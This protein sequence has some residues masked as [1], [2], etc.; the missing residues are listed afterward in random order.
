MKR[1]SFISLGCFRNRY[2][3]E[4]LAASLLSSKKGLIDPDK[5]SLKN[6]CD[7]LV[8]NTCG[9][10]DPAKL[11]SLEVI[12][13]A[14]NLK[15]AKK[16]KEVYVFGC[17]VQR[18]RPQL[19]KNFPEVDKWWGRQDFPKIYQKRLLS[20]QPVD[21]VKICEGCINRCSYCAIPLIKGP[22]RSRPAQEILK[23]VKELEAAGV[24]ELNIIGQDT[25]SWAKDLEEEIDLTGL[26]QLILDKT[27]IE[28][29]RLIYAHPQH[30]TDSLINLIAKQERICNYIDLPIQHINQRILKLMHRQVTPE[31]IISLIKE[32]REKIPGVTIRTSVIAGFPT[33]TEAEFTELLDFIKKV[34]FERLG[35]FVYSKES[36]TKAAKL[37]GQIHPMTKKR[38]HRQIM[39]TQQKISAECLEKFIGQNIK[40]LVTEKGKD[41]YLARSQYDGPEVD[42]LVLVK[43]KNLKIGRFYQVKVIDSLEYDL[44][45]Q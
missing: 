37:P 32:I 28:W 5:I 8:V 41:F 17:L 14:V 29:I 22:L 35:A 24:K 45:A 12:A 13:E 39:Q 36:E 33:E 26:I 44:V 34:R 4:V 20:R 7:I 6:R 25:T 3:S 1:V 40:V 31:R 15:K 19:E 16:V 9:F 38:R 21:F 42:G 30:I 27:K 10:I 11:E 2:D 18:F 43:R 23:E